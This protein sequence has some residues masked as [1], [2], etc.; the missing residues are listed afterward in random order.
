MI[1]STKIYLLIIIILSLIIIYP[2][3]INADSTC[4]L[5]AGGCVQKGQ[6]ATIA[7]DCCSCSIIYNYDNNGDIQCASLNPGDWVIEAGSKIGIGS[8]A[9]S[10]KITYRQGGTDV[11][12]SLSELQLQNEIA[13][14]KQLFHE[15]DALRTEKQNDLNNKF[16]TSI[17]QSGALILMFVDLV[18][19]LFYI[20]ELKLIVYIMFKL[21]P[22]LFFKLRD[23]IIVNFIKRI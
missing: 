7:T 16:N 22:S 3:S 23:S 5:N 14:Q 19:L 12:Y 1:R 11:T 21:I 4:A 18:M 6:F 2:F 9:I 10:P 8:G 20:L 17:S 13:S 15:K